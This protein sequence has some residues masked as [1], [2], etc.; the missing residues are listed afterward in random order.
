MIIRK[1][2][3]SEKSAKEIAESL[4]VEAV[5]QSLLTGIRIAVSELEVKL[6]TYDPKDS[7][8]MYPESLYNAHQIGL[9][10]LKSAKTVEDFI[11]GCYETGMW[12]AGD[13]LDFLGLDAGSSFRMDSDYKSYGYEDKLK[14]I[15]G[16]DLDV[17]D[18]QEYLEN[19]PT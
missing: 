9:K 18:V 16:G 8:G 13:T 17:W 10:L 5:S 2:L 4:L 11:Y 15:N 7:D 3:E 1:E 6:S 14:E 19:M 12:S